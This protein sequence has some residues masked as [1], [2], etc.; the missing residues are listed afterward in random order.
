MSTF[1]MNADAFDTGEGLFDG[2]LSVSLIFG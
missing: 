2:I 1:L